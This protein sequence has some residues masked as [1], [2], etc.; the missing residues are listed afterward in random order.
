MSQAAKESDQSHED[1]K[2][3]QPP[4]DKE[5]EH[6]RSPQDD[7]AMGTDIK[8]PRNKVLFTSAKELETNGIDIGYIDTIDI[9]SLSPYTGPK[10][11]ETHGASDYRREF[12]T[13][14]DV[15]ALSICVD[16]F[17]KFYLVKRSDG[18]QVLVTKWNDEPDSVM[19]YSK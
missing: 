11:N 19:Y 12:D 3:K 10:R 14:E 15:A 2:R 1:V 9:K 6:E 7:E 18:Q 13:V 17:R 4:S 16:S 5:V 8:K